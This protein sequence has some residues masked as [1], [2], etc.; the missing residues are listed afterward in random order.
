MISRFTLFLL[1][2]CAI[3][4]HGQ[5]ED[6][7]LAFDLVD[8]ETPLNVLPEL[9]VEPFQLTNAGIDEGITGLR[10]QQPLDFDIDDAIRL[11]IINADSPVTRADSL[12]LEQLFDLIRVT[13]QDDTL[14]Y[15]FP[16]S[17]SFWFSFHVE[18]AGNFEMIINPD[19]VNGAI[20]GNFDFA[21]LKGDC[22]SNPCAEAVFCGSW[23]PLSCFNEE[24]ALTNNVFESE[25]YAPTGLSLIHI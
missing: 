2:F 23:G 5:N 8:R 15:Q 22:P 9:R 1:V 6:C 7:P 4:L 12:A 19:E 13:N 20:G 11:Q 24:V 10:C 21:I 3:T 17:R 25:N 14:P 16:E 18:Q